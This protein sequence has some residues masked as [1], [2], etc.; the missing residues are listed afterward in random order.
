MVSE[1]PGSALIGPQWHRIIKKEL[2]VG[3]WVGNKINSGEWH[4][5]MQDNEDVTVEFYDIDDGDF[6][7]RVVG[8][9][10]KFVFR[11]AS[12]EEALKRY[13]DLKKRRESK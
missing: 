10:G 9:L 6:R 7:F 4:T 5:A 11:A 3:V 12:P 1:R 2:V 13:E 8:P